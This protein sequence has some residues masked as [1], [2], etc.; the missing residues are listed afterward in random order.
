LP[1]LGSSTS[2]ESPTA[3]TPPKSVTGGSQPFAGSGSGDHGSN[4]P[5]GL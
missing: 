2:S 4:L 5:S 3:S 1:P